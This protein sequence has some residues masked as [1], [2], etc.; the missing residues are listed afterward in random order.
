MHEMKL[1][2]K[3]YDYIINGTKR[4]ELRVNDEKRQ[5]IEIG[6]IITFC[7]APELKESF[8]VKVVELINTNSFKELLKVLS[9]EE[10]ADKEIIKEELLNILEQFYSKEEQKQYGVVGIRFI[11]L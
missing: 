11:L 6:D 9:V 3:Y 4:V 2:A 8:Q 1:Q 10:V 7:K 5:K